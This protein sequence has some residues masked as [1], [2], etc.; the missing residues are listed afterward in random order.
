[1]MHIHHM[2]TPYLSF[3][4]CVCTALRKT[5]RAVTRVYDE[6]LSG[7]GLTTTQFA[8][9]RYLATDREM[10]LSRLAER[11]VMDRTTLYRTLAPI[12]RRGLVTVQSISPRVKAV[13]LTSAGARIREDATRSWEKAQ[14][15]VTTAI[16]A[17]LWPALEK[18]LSALTD[19]MV[20]R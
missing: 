2:T 8:I 9:L 11:L 20:A 19:A 12:E 16:G 10:A 14:A 4:P 3:D 6:A 18:Q 17:E 5:T 1:M 13:T 7:H 15:T